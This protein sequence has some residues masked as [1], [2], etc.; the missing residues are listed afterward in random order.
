MMTMHACLKMAHNLRVPDQNDISQ[1]Y[2]MLEI[3]HSG[4][5]PSVYGALYNNRMQ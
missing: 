2:N 3:H 1:L 4:L 5:A